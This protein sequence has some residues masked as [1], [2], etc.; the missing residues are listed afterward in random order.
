MADTVTLER[1]QFEK[2]NKEK[3]DFHL[4]NDNIT[5]QTT[6]LCISCKKKVVQYV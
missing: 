3:I 5:R 2:L 6:H 4:C 1:A